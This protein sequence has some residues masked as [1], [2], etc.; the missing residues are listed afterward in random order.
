MLTKRQQDTLNFIR[1]YINENGEAPLVTEIAEGLGIS[2]QGTAHRYI[3][4]LIDGGY[5]ERLTGRTR[6]L[7]LNEQVFSEQSLVF[8]MMGK[9]AAGRLIEAVADESEI[10]L[11]SMFKGKGRYVL[12]ISGESMIGK[13]IMSGDYVVVESTRQARHGDMIVA[14]VDGYDATL[15]TML[16]NKDGTITLMPAN[17]AFEPVKIDAKRLSIQ[18]VVV[19]QLRTYP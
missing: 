4:A 2:S 14:L 13:G 8:P 9:I 16:V 6:G 12:K 3:Q 17:E 10:D 19:G 5:L 11:G 18:G 1:Q 7:K 15:K